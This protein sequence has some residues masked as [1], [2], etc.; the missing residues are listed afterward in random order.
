MS[1]HGGELWGAAIT[2][3]RGAVMNV[4][5]DVLRRCWSLFWHEKSLGFADFT[6]CS[7]IFGF[8]SDLDFS[9]TFPDFLGLF[10]ISLDFL[11]LFRSSPIFFRRCFG[12]DGFT[13]RISEFHLFSAFPGFFFRIFV[14]IFKIYQFFPYF[15]GFSKLF[16]EFR[17]FFPDFRYFLWF[18]GSCPDFT[19]FSKGV[20]VFKCWFSG[21][22]M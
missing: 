6:G 14:G 22:F 20:P 2:G 16:P 8:F 7:G 3:A 5:E 19:A 11:G 13:K 10:R 15:A 12:N 18:R 1:R 4:L 17:R 9:G 21:I